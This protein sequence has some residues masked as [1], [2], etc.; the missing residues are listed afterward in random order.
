MKVMFEVVGNPEIE[1]LL[2]DN[3]E[4]VLQEIHDGW[5][6]AVSEDC[7]FGGVE[8]YIDFHFECQYTEIGDVEIDFSEYTIEFDENEVFNAIRDLVG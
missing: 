2:N 7:W 6:D 4:Q 1:M 5:K 8:S 3:V